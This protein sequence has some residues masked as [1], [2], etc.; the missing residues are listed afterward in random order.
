MDST[1]AQMVVARL[2]TALKDTFDPSQ[3]NKHFPKHKISY[4]KKKL[5]NDSYSTSNKKENVRIEG[6]TL[7]LPKIGYV[8]IVLHRPLM[9]NIKNITILFE[10]N[11]WYVSL[12]QEVEIK[13]AKK[14]L[15]TIMGY[16]LN[17]NDIVVD[18]FG[19]KVKNPK[20]LKNSE[21]KI[22]DMQRQL[23]RRN[24]GG[25]NWQKTKARLN[26]IQGKVKRQ[27]LDFSH[28]IS[29]TIAKS[30]DIVVFEDLY[31]KG[32]QQFNGRMVQDNHFGMLPQLI[33][34]KVEREGGLFY[35]INR[36]EKSTGICYHC[37]TQHKVE[38]KER[39]FTCNNC[40]QENDRDTS[41]AKHIK[42]VGENDL[43]AG[44][45][46]VRIKQSTACAKV[47]VKTKVF[48]RKVSKLSEDAKKK[49]T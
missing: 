42:L 34:Y 21:E 38:L 6:D 27:R 14:V 13:D 46:L 31:V 30:S 36:F 1:A 12:V 3:P 33:Q 15:S 22:K 48:E 24:K 37:K 7:K 49:E 11:H 10:H 5:H 17:S 8:P 47:G 41:S 44:G 9:S 23:A 4:Q 20:F 29:N 40:G 19:N 25:S 18:N 39:C 43:I 45:T 16:D 2:D 26:K 28:K 32:M 35:K